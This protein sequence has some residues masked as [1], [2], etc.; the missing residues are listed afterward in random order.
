MIQN[1]PMAKV[2]VG[3]SGGVDSA[4]A[5]ALL[6]EQ[7]HEVTAGY[8][9]NWVNDEGIP[10]DCPW[11][12][13]IEDAHAVAQAL[14]IE[15]RV[16]DLIDSYRSRI[17]DQL[18]DGYRSGIT[19]NP[20]VWCNREMKF[21]VFLDYALAQGFERVATGHYARRRQGADGRAAV[22]RG[23]D[24]NKDQ[25]YFLALMTQHQVAHA[26]FPTGEM[27]KP[28]VREVAR[29]FALPVAEKK[30]SQGICF[31]GQ[32]KMSDFLRH[33]LPDKP[34]EIVDV[35]GR[36]LGEHRGLHLYTLGQRKGHGVAS[37]REGMAYVVVGKETATNR[38]VLGWDQAD[39]AGLYTTAWT[40]GMVS[41]IQEP[42][43]SHTLIDAQ[44]RYRAKA[45][46]ARVR[47]TGEGT[48]RIDFEKPQRA[49][50][51][52]QI[53]AF[54]EGGRLLGGGVFQ[55]QADRH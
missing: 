13:D 34:G 18:I 21:G 12:Q 29:R 25:S 41:S 10:G 11:Q 36:V 45:E 50:A 17:V 19:P 22:L 35:T 39:T 24:P 8:M 1:H 2:L 38:L 33:Y 46:P 4:V 40:V 9:K 53:C 27:L 30:D 32:V 16:V 23:A 6:V 48:V 14:G 52:G 15:F 51:P 37:P 28:E 5:A 20:D 44:P 54:Y 47:A 3:L 31:L 26:M 49:I 43:E 55:A 7:G 42:V